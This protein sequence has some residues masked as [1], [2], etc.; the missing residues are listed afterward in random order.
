MFKTVAKDKKTRKYSLSVE[1]YYVFVICEFSEL[2]D[3]FFLVILIFPLIIL[4]LPISLSPLFET[5]TLMG[6]VL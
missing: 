4:S 6:S 2:V 1:S 5:H 3:I